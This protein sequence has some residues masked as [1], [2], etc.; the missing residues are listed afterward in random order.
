[1]SR[2]LRCTAV[3]LKRLDS[4]R[5][6]EIAV[7][8]CAG[9]A[10]AGARAAGSAL[11]PVDAGKE[12]VDGDGALRAGLFALMAADAAGGADLFGVRAVVIARA[13]HLCADDIRHDLNDLLGT[14]LR[15]D[16]AADA[17]RVV[18]TGCLLYTSD[19]ADEL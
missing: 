1:M 6:G 18:D 3:F 4:G 7:D 17:R 5:A 11:V 8:H 14:R 19:A 2:G 9:R 13:E 10:D 16:A 15:A 12:I